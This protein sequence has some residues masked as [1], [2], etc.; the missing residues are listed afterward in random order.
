MKRKIISFLLAICLILPCAFV[1]NACS[2]PQEEGWKKDK[3][4][5]TAWANYVNLNNFYVKNGT[6]EEISNN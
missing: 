6:A 3:I 2:T 4:S 1:L 5:A